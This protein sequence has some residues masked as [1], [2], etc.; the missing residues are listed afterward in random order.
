MKPDNLRGLQDLIPFLNYLDKN[1][2]YYRL[3]HDR[4]DS[5][6]VETT[7]LGIRLEID[8][9]DDTSNTACFRVTK[10]CLTMCLHCSP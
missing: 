10:A 9:M 2:V 3:S 8:F 1:N 5:I 4:D 7:L 6:M